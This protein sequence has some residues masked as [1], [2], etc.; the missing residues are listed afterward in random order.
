LHQ[1]LLFLPG[2]ATY[3]DRLDRIAAETVAVERRTLMHEV[4]LRLPEYQQPSLVYPAD[5]M[6][7]VKLLASGEAT[8]LAGNALSLR[9][10]AAK[11]G[12]SGLVEVPV[13]AMT[14]HLATRAGHGA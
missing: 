13:K 11:I 5:Q 10:S 1:V 12:I 4:L 8:A 7:A 3:P 9:F 2:R 6:D 14:Y